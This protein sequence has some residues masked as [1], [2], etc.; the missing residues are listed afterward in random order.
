MRLATVVI[1]AVLA[2]MFIPV[3]DAV[4]AKPGKNGYMAS[5]QQKIND[6]GTPGGGR[7]TSSAGIVSVHH[8]GSYRQKS[9]CAVGGLSVCGEAQRCEN[10]QV[11][12]QSWYET[13]EGPEDRRIWCPGMASA[14]P[15]GA[16]APTLTP[17]RILE[18]FKTIELPAAPLVIQPPKGRT[19]VNLES[20]RLPIP[21]GSGALSCA[22]ER[23]G[24]RARV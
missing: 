2:F 11:M 13:A 16:K 12:Q 1:S 23:L 4:T 14:Q 19:L 17:G 6:T 20:T 21:P 9:V 3:A 5:G 22:R 18:A 24:S 8:Q 7:D 10:G 15:P